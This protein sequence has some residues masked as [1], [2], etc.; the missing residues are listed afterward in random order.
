MVSGT[1]ISTFRDASSAVSFLRL[2]TEEKTRIED[3][4]TKQQ[5]ILTS[6]IKAQLGG[7]C[8]S[9]DC[10]WHN[11][12]GTIGCT[13]VRALQID[14]KPGGHSTE[15]RARHGAGLAGLYRVRK[16]LKQSAIAGIESLYQL[17][18]ANCNWIKRFENKEAR[19]A[20]QHKRPARLRPGLQVKGRPPRR[21]R[22]TTT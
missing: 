2:T 19:G 5:R 7:R 18:C 17:L 22:K 1:V 15:L 6:E 12:D 3:K 14:Y 16:N 21:I 10:R 20:D 11:D 8:A 13:D 9:P 4:S